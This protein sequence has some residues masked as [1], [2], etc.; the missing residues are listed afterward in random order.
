VFVDMES[1][2]NCTTESPKTGHFKSWQGI[3]S[4]V[5]PI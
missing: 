2:M 1:I 5:P 4:L 3:P